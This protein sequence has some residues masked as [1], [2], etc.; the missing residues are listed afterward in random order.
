MKNYLTEEKK[1]Y[2]LDQMEK[3][4]K[5]AELV[6]SDARYEDTS[7]PEGAAVAGW[8]M[9]KRLEGDLHK[10][11]RFPCLQT[12]LSL[13]PRTAEEAFV[14]ASHMMPSAYLQFT[15][16]EDVS[17]EILPALQAA[18][19]ELTAE[20]VFVYWSDEAEPKEFATE[21]IPFELRDLDMVADQKRYLDVANYL[22]FFQPSYPDSCINKK[23]R[24]DK[25]KML[26]FYRKGLGTII[27]HLEKVAE[28]FTTE[29]QCGNEKQAQK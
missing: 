1:R 28:K 18:E 11:N 6:A 29:L 12:M 15:Y 19:Q 27:E 26:E 4:R 13:F 20:G 22:V 14:R 10:L 5:L 3:C 9:D 16:S 17:G 2:Y 23:R 21:R 25:N 8:A 7:E 24:I